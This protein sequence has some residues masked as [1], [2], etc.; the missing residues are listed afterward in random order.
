MSDIFT[1]PCITL[2]LDKTNSLYQHFISLGTSYISKQN[3]DNPTTQWGSL[4]NWNE[5]RLLISIGRGHRNLRDTK[6]LTFPTKFS[7]GNTH[8]NMLKNTKIN[9]QTVIITLVL[10]CCYHNYSLLIQFQLFWL[11]W[12]AENNKIVNYT[13]ITEMNSI[14]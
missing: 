14:I 7:Q 6:T 11:A 5:K 1:D 3:F 9:R 2:L 8:W 12:W 13:Y 4:Q 10:A